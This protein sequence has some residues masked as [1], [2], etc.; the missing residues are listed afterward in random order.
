[1][2]S[3][4]LLVGDFVKPC[5]HLLPERKCGHPWRDGK[6]VTQGVCQHC[7]YYQEAV[8]IDPRVLEHVA[9][10]QGPCKGCGG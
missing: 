5:I 10:Q 6:S 8:I 2:E 3:R 9:K 4:P 7:K 1:M